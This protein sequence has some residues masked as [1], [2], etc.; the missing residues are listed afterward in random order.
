[1]SQ[2]TARPQSRPLSPHLTIWK[3]GPHMLVSIL[4]RMCGVALATVGTV[5]FVW[6][7]AAL[8]GG[9]DSYTIFHYWVVKETD[10]NTLG[11]F[12][13]LVAKIAAVGLTWAFFQHLANGIRHFILDIGAGYE[14]KINR[15]G[16]LATI[17]FSITATALV[18][19]YVLTK[20][21]AS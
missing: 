7:L 15:M 4:H 2:S 13:N 20:G 16:A 18:W 1:M 6:W 9:P 19:A 12:A 14:L 21:M 17:A 10:G 8:A 11:W 3:W 5:V